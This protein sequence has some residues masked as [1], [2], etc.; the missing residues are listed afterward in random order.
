M[1]NT[2]GKSALLL[3]ALLACGGSDHPTQPD[4]GPAVPALEA[5]N[6]AALGN[7]KI[8][9]QRIGPLPT[10]FATAYI[11][12]AATSTSSHIFDNVGPDGVVLSPDGQRVA[13]MK[14]TGI[15]T[16]YDIHLANVDGTGVTQVTHFPGDG[17][18]AWR[19]DGARIVFVSGYGDSPNIF[20]QSPLPNASDLTQ[21]TD[22][23][24]TGGTLTC[25]TFLFGENERV[26]MANDGRIAFACGTG[27]INL[28]SAAG[29]LASAYVPAHSDQN[30]LPA[31]F[32]P[33]WSP[34][35]TRVAFIE[36]T[37]AGSNQ[38]P[39]SRVALKL[40]NADATN[41]TTLAS[42]PVASGSVSVG[43]TW[44]GT[45]NVS[46][47]WMPDGSRIVFTVPET[48]QISHLWVAKSDGTG[49]TQLTTAPGYDRSVSCSRS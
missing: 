35:A 28:L 19:P 36:E 12:N 9:F 6:F 11:V 25:P 46:L 47:C 26:S 43:G 48:D 1:R 15:Q 5:L 20:S 7:G 21:H 14:Y 23:K 10:P 27:E 41:V 34:D 45:G 3:V 42:L 22:F 16:G 24:V 17:T 31:V 44:A 13:F 38:L 39:V 33:E 32:D 29:T 37:F 2:Y 8:A 18:P 30:N 40:M 49:L 4:P